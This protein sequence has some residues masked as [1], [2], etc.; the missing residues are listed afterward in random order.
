LRR[1]NDRT[2]KRAWPSPPSNEQTNAQKKNG[3]PE[4]PGEAS[5]LIPQCRR[6]SIPSCVPAGLSQQPRLLRLRSSAIGPFAASDGDFLFQAEEILRTQSA[7]H[8]FKAWRHSW[9]HSWRHFGDVLSS[10]RYLSALLW[11]GAWLVRRSSASI[12]VP[13][14]QG[15]GRYARRQGLR[16]DR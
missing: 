12:R 5:V 14:N 4:R 3:Y 15:G 13:K 9:R 1:S 2:G 6:S 7:P 11:L 10:R 16:I 8:S